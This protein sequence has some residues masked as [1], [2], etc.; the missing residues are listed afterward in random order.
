[1][2]ILPRQRVRS[3]PRFRFS[4]K[5]FSRSEAE[6]IDDLTRQ[7]DPRVKTEGRAIFPDG[8][9]TADLAA[10]LINDDDAAIG[11]RFMEPRTDVVAVAMKL[12]ALGMEHSVEVIA[13]SDLEYCGLERFGFRVERIS[14]QTPQ[15]R[16]QCL[17]QI[18]Q[19]WSLDLI[20]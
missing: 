4:P 3:I 15:Q 10:K 7:H 20:L 19:F 11:I 17:S 9:F 14:G 2:T 1:M 13:L 16:E 5:R 6:N 12:A 18:R 8:C